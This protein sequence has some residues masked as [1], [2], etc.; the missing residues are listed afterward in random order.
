MNQ[1]RYGANIVL[2]TLM[3]LILLT[4]CASGEVLQISTQQALTDS[5]P[6]SSESIST[7]TA[8]VMQATRVTIPITETRAID[9]TVIT[10][11]PTFMAMTMSVLEPRPYFIQ[12]V[13]PKEYRIVPLGLYNYIPEGTIGYGIEAF[14]LD[15]PSSQIPAYQSSVCVRPLAELLVQKGDDFGGT[16]GNEDKFKGRMD[17]LVNGELKDGV[18]SSGGVLSRT[19]GWETVWIEGA[20]YCWKVPLGTGQHQVT[21]RFHQTSGDIQEY[22]WYFE[23]Q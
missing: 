12:A 8:H 23:I 19:D 2:L 18:Q 3:S 4:A 6:Q 7:V 20:D 22:T 16:R 10:P 13:A 1:T 21:F 9:L 14:D 11:Y 17:L 5:P 15:I